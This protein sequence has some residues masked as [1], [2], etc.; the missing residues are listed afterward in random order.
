MMRLLQIMMLTSDYYDINDEGAG[1]EDKHQIDK[2]TVL[3][4]S[5]P[6]FADKLDALAKKQEQK[7]EPSTWA[8]AFPR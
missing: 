8:A 2:G 1:L 7:K 6:A 5:L 4:K 3:I